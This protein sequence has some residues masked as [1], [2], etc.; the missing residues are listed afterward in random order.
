MNNPFKAFA[1]FVICIL[2]MVFLGSCS[3][4]H[5]GYNYQAHR[6]KSAK[7]VKKTVKLNRGSRDLTQH[8]ALCGRH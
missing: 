6:A 1:V 7:L 5:H 2:L 4:Q 8:R 3:N